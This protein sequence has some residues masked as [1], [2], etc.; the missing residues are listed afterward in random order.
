MQI[1]H[2]TLWGE[3]DTYQEPTGSGDTDIACLERRDLVP[4]PVG[5]VDSGTTPAPS[6]LRSGI[7]N[8]QGQQTGHNSP[9][10]CM[11]YLRERFRGQNLSE[12]ASKFLLPSWRQKNSWSYDH[13]FGK[14]VCWCQQ[15]DTNLTSGDI[16]EVVN[17]LT[18][19]Y[20]QG[21]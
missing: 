18:D 15:R 14:W 12:E 21:Y 2:G 8:S 4:S 11:G 7:T 1:L 17:F 6:M 19:L 13:M 3:S 10:S 5:D 20:Q 9:A 16:N